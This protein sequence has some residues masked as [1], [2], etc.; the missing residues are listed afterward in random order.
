MSYYATTQSTTC[1]HRTIGTADDLML[2]D[3]GG[4]WVVICEDHH[5]VLNTRTLADARSSATREFCEACQALDGFH[6]L[7][8]SH[9]Y[10]DICD[11]LAGMAAIDARATG[12]I[13][14]TA[15][16]DWAGSLRLSHSVTV[17]R[18]VVEGA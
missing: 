2:D 3:A 18:R 5:T 10:C 14:A 4:K 8:R 16:R 6:V 17:H 7:T 11:E 1:G 13:R 15:T 12:S 9:A